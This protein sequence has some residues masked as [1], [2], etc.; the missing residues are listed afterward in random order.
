MKRLGFKSLYVK[1]TVMFLGILWLSSLT[2]FRVSFIN[3]E[4]KLIN[5]IKLQLYERA[6]RSL[7]LAEKYS[8][9]Q[10]DLLKVLSDE[11]VKVYIY[12]TAG[13][14]AIDG[15]Q[16]TETEMSALSKGQIV[17]GKLSGHSRLPFAAFKTGDTIILISPNISNNTI[18][19]FRSMIGLVL[20]ICVA[21]GSM[22]I[23]IAS[24]MIVKPIKKLTEAAKEVS[25]GNFDV[26]IETKSRDEIGQL[27]DTFNIMTRELKNIE[28]LRKDFISSVSHEF[29]T[30]MTS[31]QGF[32]KLLKDRTLSRE[33]SDE[34]ADIIISETG[35]LENL[36]SNL[37][38]LSSLEN[39]S[40]HENYRS[41]SLDEQI[42][43]AIL[44]MENKWS[45]KDIELDLDLDK[46]TFKGDE[47]LMYQVWINLISNAIKFSGS[48]GELKIDL[49]ESDGRI[50]ISIGDKG[51]GIADEDKDRV[52][53]RFYKADKS[54]TKEGSG[55]GLPIV[56]K[57]VELHG[58]RVYF[59]S[60]LGKGTTFF[61][62]LK[63]QNGTRNGY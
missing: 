2:A 48:G 34:Y 33:Q 19:F 30:P 51:I 14:L 28:Y 8:M 12:D 29:R 41:F 42:R 3:M 58:G 27:T 43:R 61:I 60:E 50:K 16:L 10:Q 24:R 57:I 31:I 56:K 55:L 49:K 59:E 45:E 47:E 15:A 7:Q 21:M 63:Q 25:K 20:V 32:A 22:L 37:L 52:F 54:R 40:I 13:E 26:K 53:E 4:D 35:R 36:S 44:L 11:N 9:E 5:Y 17:E 39:K 1:F 38:K 62:E 46:V 6:S 23:A 18:R